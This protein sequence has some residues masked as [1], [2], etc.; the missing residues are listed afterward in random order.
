M[1]VIKNTKNLER[2][3]GINKDAL[4]SSNTDINLLFRLVCEPMEGISEPFILLV[5]A[6]DEASDFEKLNDFII[7]IIKTCP[8]IRLII[9]STEDIN[10]GGLSYEEVILE[11]NKNDVE[12]FIKVKAGSVGFKPEEIEALINCADG[13]YKFAEFAIDNKII[14]T[15]PKKQTLI[16]CTVAIL[17][18]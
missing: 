7:L 9:T 16:V 3:V 18:E 8:N 11:N 14:P 6:I 10:F 4:N 5:D 2:F 13:N 15:S 17:S 12:E 1:R